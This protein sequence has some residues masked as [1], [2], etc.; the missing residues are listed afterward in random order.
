MNGKAVDESD[1]PSNK[2]ASHNEKIDKRR[3]AIM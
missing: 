2:L 1:C 3:K